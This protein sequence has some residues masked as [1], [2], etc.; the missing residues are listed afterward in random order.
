MNVV[1]NF[2]ITHPIFPWYV[3]ATYGILILLGR[4]FFEKRR[5]W[6]LR[7]WLS[8]HNLG[9]TLFSMFGMIRVVPVVLWM[10]FVREQSLFVHLCQDVEFEYGRGSQGLWVQLFV[11][12]KFPEMLD[13]FFI[14]VHKKPLIFLHWYHHITVLLF[15][16]YSYSNKMP[17]GPIFIAMNYSVHAVMYGYYFSVSIS[18][19]KAQQCKNKISILSLIVTISQICQMVVGCALTCMSLYLFITDDKCHIS[20]IAILSG[21]LMYGSYLALFLQFFTSKYPMVRSPHVNNKVKFF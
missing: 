19:R 7:F 13:T 2:I 1:W 10:L 21:T 11:L 4:K 8:A 16:W 18:S 3:C 5:P 17:S 14:V 20:P 9:L 6:N 12:S 15:T